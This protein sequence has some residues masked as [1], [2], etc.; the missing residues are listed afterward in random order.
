VIE[1]ISTGDV[2]VR[3]VTSVDGEL[4]A[5]LDRDDNQVAVYSINDYRLLRHI[6]LPG[7]K[8]SDFSDMTS[9]VRH[10]C[11]YA[12]DFDN[13]CI[14]R[15]DLSSG[16][17]AAVK[18]IKS[19]RISKWSVPGEPRSLSVTPGSCN[20]LVACWEPSKL[21]ELRA[22]SG[23][24]VRQITLQSDIKCLLHAVQLT[25]GPYVV[26][27][28]LRGALNRVCM[29]DAEGRVT[30]S[31]GGQCGSDVGHLNWPYHLAVDENSQF[32]FVADFGNTRVVMLSPTLEFVRELSETVLFSCRL[33]FHQTTRRL[34]VGESPSGVA[35]IEL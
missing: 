31:Y 19:R 1:T 17:I 26:C 24:V 16:L 28:G 20:L 18:R 15:Y 12:S 27:H 4:C 30:R 5:L 35:V 33:Y 9:C 21:V 13:R 14:H 11:L 34:F 3:G 29:V 6:H 25:T 10:K 32:I 7:L 23:Q 22:D 8:P 2:G